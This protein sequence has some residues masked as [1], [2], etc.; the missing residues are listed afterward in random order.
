MMKHSAYVCLLIAAIGDVTIPLLLA[1][2]DKNY[3]HKTMVLSALG[4]PSSPVHIIYNTW[5]VLAGI[6]LLMGAVKMGTEFQSASKGLSVGIMACLSVFAVCSCIVS[7]LFPVGETK[8]LDTPSAKIHGIGAVVGFLMLVVSALLIGLLL[9]RMN[10]TC[11]GTIAI[12]SFVCAFI[13]YVLLA[14]ADKPSFANTF[15]AWEGLWE[16]LCL[17]FSYLPVVIVSWEK[18]RES[19]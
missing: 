11:A 3:H 17:V 12:I 6:F 15:I 18:V 13:C 10:H 4:N 9:L 7:A 16:H 19:L 1:P 8:T 2:F 14:M 5:L